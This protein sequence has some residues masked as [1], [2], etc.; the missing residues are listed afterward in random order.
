M[1]SCG[2]QNFSSSCKI[3]LTRNFLTRTRKTDS[4][5]LHPHNMRTYGN[6]H[7]AVHKAHAVFELSR[8]LGDWT[9][10]VGDMSPYSA[11]TL[12]TCCSTSS[13]TSCWTC[14]WTWTRHVLQRN[15]SHYSNKLSNLLLNLC[16]RMLLEPFTLDTSWATSWDTFS[17]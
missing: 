14:C 1:Q 4:T 5:I 8:V 15:R 6:Q 3:E 9:P 11:F 7:L 16:P 17:C 13:A 10:L 2:E 12:A